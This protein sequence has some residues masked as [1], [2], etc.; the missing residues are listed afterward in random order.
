MEKKIKLTESEIKDFIQN[1]LGYA[2]VEGCDILRSDL[3]LD[4]ANIDEL[5]KACNK[6]FEA[7]ADTENLQTVKQLI[8]RVKNT[9]KV[10]QEALNEV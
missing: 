2:H 9:A 6:N 3:R 1:F 5:V 4:N 10:N 7:N 8:K